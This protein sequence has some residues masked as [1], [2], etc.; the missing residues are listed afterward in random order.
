[1][2]KTTTV[3]THNNGDP[4][5]LKA[6]LELNASFEL[7]ALKTVEISDVT[8]IAKKVDAVDAFELEQILHDVLRK[9]INDYFRGR[10]NT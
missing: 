10:K 8:L 5:E 1:M 7:N 6:T 2:A 9:T 4:Y 3:S